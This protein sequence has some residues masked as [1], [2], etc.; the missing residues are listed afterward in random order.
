MQKYQIFLASSINEFKDERNEIGDLIRK[1]QDIL[2]DYEIKIKLFE[3]EFFDNTIA[4]GRKQGEYNE[5]IK[6]SQSFIM[7][8]GSKLGQYT[9]EEYNIAINSQIPIYVL[10]K[11]TQYDQSVEDFKN[12]IDENVNC[13]NYTTIQEMKTVI[14]KIIQNL[15]K[16]EISIQI[17]ENKIQI[18]NKYIKL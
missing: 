18:E 5:Q 2:I 11:N 4:L 6:K 1:I 12:Q 13:Y 17:K 8:V 9:L 10:F 16:T 15:C 3:C 7:L 14:A